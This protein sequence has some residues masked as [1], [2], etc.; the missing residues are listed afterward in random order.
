MKDIFDK[1]KRIHEKSTKKFGVQN[2]PMCT[3]IS[4]ITEEIGEAAKEANKHDNKE[5]NDDYTKEDFEFVQWERKRD[6]RSELIDVI[7]TCV[8][9]IESLD[10]NA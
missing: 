4:I 10:R 6:Y 8:K 3:W 7:N 9:A 1:V 2:H 5:E